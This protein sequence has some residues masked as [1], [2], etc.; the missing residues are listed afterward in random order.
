[1]NPHDIR[2]QFPFFSA[3]PDIVYLDNAA[4]THKPQ[5]V[6]DTIN[7]FYKTQNANAGRGSYPL[8][9]TLANDI[10]H[11]RKQT[12]IFLNAK[13]TEEIF[14]T[15][16]ATDSFNKIA[17]SISFFYLEDGDEVLYCPQDHQSFAL[18][19]VSM[20]RT[21]RRL[22]KT[23]HLIP[24]RVKKTGSIDRDDLYKKITKKTKVANI[25]HVH[26]VYGSDNDIRDIKHHLPD[27]VILNVDATQSV[28]HMPV[29]VQALGCDI[30]SFS[31]HK[32]FASQGVGVTYIAKR[33][34][35]ILHPVWIGG[36]DGVTLEGNDIHL[37]HYTRAFE[38]GTQHYAGILSLG[39]AISFLESIGLETIHRHLAFLTQELVKQLREIPNIEFAYGPAY[40]PCYDGYGIVSFRLRS[41]PSTEAGFL[42][43]EQGICV[44]TG[45]HCLANPTEDTIRVSMHVYNTEEDI[46]RFINTLTSLLSS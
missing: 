45:T 33:L 31:G 20:Q 11:V 39:T 23:I 13:H 37:N 1:M 22:G 3:H 7:N 9:R 30:L 6:I 44:R 43:G 24:L 32:M 2:K 8:A 46:E 26:N 16:G 41:L 18:P 29:D 36:G 12:Q 19:W 28:G 42:L 10:E 21:L 15:F 40:W 4:T 17:L 14:F 25:T 34:H 27:T 38:S 35:D 5:T